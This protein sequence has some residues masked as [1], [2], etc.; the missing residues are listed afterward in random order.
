MKSLQGHFLIASPHLADTNFYKGVVLMI[1]HDEEGAFG[2]ILNRP[3]ENT[4]AEIWKMV[5]EEDV[6]CPEPIFF[7]G[8]VSGPLLALH[9]L[10][11]AAE[12]EIVPGI[13]FAAHKDKLQKLIRQTTKPF[14][15]FTGYAGWAAGQLEEEL[16]AGGWLTAKINKK[17]I[18][19]S[20][21]D[22]WEQVTRTIG[23]SILT[24][25]VKVKHVPQDP[26][27]N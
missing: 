16:S 12:M 27:L 4:V 25:A 24:K 9:R 3:T 26:S 23:E 10:K 14:R 19:Q 15:F 20:A 2:L 5:G 8:P 1:K 21:D 22:L 17:L 7:G 11:S 13:Y 6:E 18:F